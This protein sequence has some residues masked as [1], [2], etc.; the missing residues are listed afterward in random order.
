MVENKWDKSFICD[1]AISNK[2]IMA[3][4]AFKQ[5]IGMRE[6]L[7]TLIRFIPKFF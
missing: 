3:W 4:D 7:H 5:S 2:E 6:C 1:K